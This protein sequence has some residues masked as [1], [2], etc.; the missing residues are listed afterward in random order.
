MIADSQVQKQQDI[1]QS[2]TQQTPDYPQD[3][4]QQV[5]PQ[6]DSKAPTQV[7]TQNEF[8]TLNQLRKMINCALATNDRESYD[9]FLSVSCQWLSKNLT[10]LRFAQIKQFFDS[11]ISVLNENGAHITV[12]TRNDRRSLKAYYRYL[13]LI[14]ER[15]EPHLACGIMKFR[16]QYTDAANNLINISCSD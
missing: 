6:Q 4:R 3:Q 14:W 11:V 9:D 16:Q 5:D 1:V 2:Q 8:I 12:S 15:I 10:E 13:D 7:Q